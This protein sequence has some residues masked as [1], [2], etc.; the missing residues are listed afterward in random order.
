MK[1]KLLILLMLVASVSIAQIRVDTKTSSAATI[2][3]TNNTGATDT[4][5]IYL[6]GDSLKLGNG[7]TGNTS[8]NRVGFQSMI[9]GAIAYD[10]CYPSA[11]GFGVGAAAPSFTIYNTG[12]LRAYEFVN[13]GIKELNLQFE[14]YHM[15][16]EGDTIHPHLHLY[17]P[18]NGNAGNIRFGFE[19]TWANMNNTG[20]LVTTTIYLDVPRA[21]NAGI[22]NNFYVEFPDIIGTGKMISSIVACRIFRDPGATQDTFTSSVWLKGCAIHYRKNTLGSHL[23]TIK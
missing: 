14:L 10:D 9:G 4:N 3:F 19:Y 22:D 17:I 23:E 20:A 12:N 16:K 5:T 21:A 6:K 1:T 11:V 8:F 18:D 2:K 13:T 7:L 15:Y